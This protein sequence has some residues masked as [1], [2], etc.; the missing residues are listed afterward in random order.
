MFGRDIEE[1]VLSLE[2]GC[3]LGQ[4]I[5]IL[6][7]HAK[8]VPHGDCFGVGAGGHFLTAGWDSVLSRKY[9]LG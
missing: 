8:A 6:V 9:G 1:Y 2:P 7:R 5:E 4:V 3:L